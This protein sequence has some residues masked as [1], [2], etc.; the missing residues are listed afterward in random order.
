MRVRSV[1]WPPILCTAGAGISMG[2]SWPLLALL[3][4]REGAS[5]F[6]IGTNASA[7]TV[8]ALLAAPL[9]GAIIRRLG[10]ISTS[11]ACISVMALC[12]IALPLVGA[13][14]AWLPLR[15]ALGAAAFTLFTTTQTWI[16]ALCREEE[17]GQVIGMFGFVWS[18]GF[19]GGPIIISVFGIEGLA[20]FLAGIACLAASAIPLAFGREQE[21]K[22]MG[23]N[24]VRGFSSSSAQHLGRCS[25]SSP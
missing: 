5:G 21:K 8:A 10:I 11:S 16:H 13:G 23:F 22:Q 25:P 9:A 7:Q 17:R 15:F 2:L 18:V 1:H 6:A 19:A 20:P 4:E 14:S 3:L 24:G 12:F